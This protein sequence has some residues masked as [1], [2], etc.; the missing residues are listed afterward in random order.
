MIRFLKNIVVVTVPALI[1]LV[2]FLEIF[3]RVG[4]PATS[5]PPACFDDVE[6]I[7]RFCSGGGEG[8]ATFGKF[9]RQRGRW[10]VNNFGWNS[11][12]DYEAEKTRPRVA[13]IGDSFIEAFQVDNDKSYPSLLR[14]AVGDRYDVYSIGISGAALSE[15]LNMS[16]YANRHFDPDVFV[17][18]VV[19]NDFLESIHEFNAHDIHMMMLSV[20]DSSITEVA[21]RADHSM[22]QFN[23]KRRWI[24][25]SAIVRYLVFNLKLQQT[26]ALMFSP[27]DFSDN[28]V[29][30][31]AVR[32][33]E[34]IRR[35]VDY[36]LGKLEEENPGKRIVF[37]RGAPQQDIYKGT[38]D[39]SP[40]LFLSDILCDACEAYGFEFIDLAGPMRADWEANHTKFNSQYD[41]HWNE[42][43]HRFVCDQLLTLGF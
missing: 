18:N 16:R 36:I 42:Y 26:L 37:V 24:R 29:I 1:L 35:A 21:P 10:R 12:V 30:D 9:A 28:I 5:F 33:A 11:P 39:E 14:S 3:F 25:K 7:F 13:V 40:V 22:S 23:W 32:Q 34:P 19:S 43:G 38:L 4:I 8:R 2:V 6:G 41:G 27:K 17:F 20:G 31:P 15:Y